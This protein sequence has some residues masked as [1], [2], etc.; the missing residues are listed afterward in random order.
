MPDF[1]IRADSVDVEQ[2]MRQIRARISEKRGVDYTEKQIQ[3]LATVKLERFFDPKNLRSDL[4]EQ[5]RKARL[6]HKSPPPPN[7]AFEETTLF[8]SHRRIVVWIR[9]LLGPV[10]KLFFNP[11]PLISALHI[12]SQLNSR[13]AQRETD[14]QALEALHYEVMHNLVVELTRLG[15]EVGNLKMRVESLS[16]R[17]D[18]DERRARAL[19]GVVQLKPEEPV[20]GERA[21]EREGKPESAAD[22][23]AARTRRRRRRRGR[24]SSDLRSGGDTAASQDGTDGV[25]DATP[26]Q[27]GEDEERLR[28]N[29]G[30]AGGGNDESPDK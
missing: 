8:E 27:A 30:E 1:T 29:G 26:T 20:A 28:E 17:L 14:L 18:F 7:Y 23:D 13:N 16:S 12:Q 21:E 6:Q 10:L 22:G 4:L 2:I 24:R 25:D 11:N 15:M 5:F 19:E 9:R 3:E